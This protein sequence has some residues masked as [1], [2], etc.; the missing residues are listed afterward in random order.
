MPVILEGGRDTATRW[1]YHVASRTRGYV[2]PP[3]SS[4]L[5]QPLPPQPPQPP[6]PPLPPSLPSQ[7][8]N[9]LPHPPPADRAALD[10]ERIRK[11]LKVLEKE[12]KRKQ[13]KKEKRSK[14]DK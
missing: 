9:C 5:Q 8:P 4:R 11:A 1:D 10:D 3:V 6:Q 12:K 7:S 14:K 13:R 2:D